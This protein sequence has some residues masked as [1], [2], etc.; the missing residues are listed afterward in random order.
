[1]LTE[2]HSILLDEGFISYAEVIFRKLCSHL[3]DDIYIYSGKSSEK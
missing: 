2:W 1:M 3:P